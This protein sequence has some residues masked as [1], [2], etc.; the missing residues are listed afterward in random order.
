[1]HRAFDGGRV[2][3]GA[4][5]EGAPPVVLCQQCGGW[6]QCNQSPLPAS[7]CRMHPTDAAADS[8]RRFRCGTRPVGNTTSANYGLR[9]S[10]AYHLE[11]DDFDVELDG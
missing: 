1:M 7:A 3:W 5:Q 8:I 2:L 6:T 10:E 9:I 11:P 4:S